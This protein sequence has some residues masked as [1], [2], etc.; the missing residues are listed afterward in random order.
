MGEDL[1]NQPKKSKEKR[2]KT[3]EEEVKPKKEKKQ[4]PTGTLETKTTDDDQLN[5]I[6]KSVNDKSYPEL[7]EQFYKSAKPEYLTNDQQQSIIPIQQR[8]DD[9]DLA[10][11]PK[12]SKEKRQKTR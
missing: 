10:N 12:K 7:E 2:Q 11:Q 6:P 4:Y 8:Q 3:R 5:I 1:A 9:E